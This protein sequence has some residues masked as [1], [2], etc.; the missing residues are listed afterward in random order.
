MMAYSQKVLHFLA[1]LDHVFLLDL[2]QELPRPCLC[3]TLLLRD[4]SVLPPAQFSQEQAGANAPLFQV[5]EDRQVALC[6]CPCR[7]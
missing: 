3:A 6:R 4:S 5:L 2:S 1:A 7:T